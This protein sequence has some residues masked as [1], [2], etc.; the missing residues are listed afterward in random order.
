MRFVRTV[1][2]CGDVDMA[3]R[4]I[5]CLRHVYERGVYDGRISK[6][7]KAAQVL[8]SKLIETT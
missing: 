2:R 6:K 5:R 8:L 7:G 1:E 3:G 4:F